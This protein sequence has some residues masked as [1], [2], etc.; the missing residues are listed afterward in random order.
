[1]SKK[2]T[3]FASDNEEPTALAYT[4]FSKPM[5]ILKGKVADRFFR[6]M[7]ENERKA[8][9]KAKKPMTLEEA[10]KQLSHEKMFLSI[11]ENELKEIKD[12]IKKLE[13]YISTVNG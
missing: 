12:R 3:I 10:E 5:P 11:K 1:M 8:A 4:D 9:E 6:I 2:N 13:N 7:E